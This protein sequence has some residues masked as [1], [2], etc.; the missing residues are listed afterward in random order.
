MPMLG[1]LAGAALLLF[2]ALAPPASAQS[3][4][5]YRLAWARSPAGGGVSAAE[6]YSL[7]ST[8][9]IPEAGPTQRGGGYTLNGGVVDAGSQPLQRTQWLYLPHIER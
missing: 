7:V 1:F 4:G 3:G 9:G 6:G 5:M 8:T 2:A